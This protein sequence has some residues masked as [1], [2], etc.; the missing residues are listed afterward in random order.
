MTSVIWQALGPHPDQP[1]ARDLARR[2]WASVAGRAT[3]SPRAAVT[4]GGDRRSQGPSGGQSPSAACAESPRPPRSSASDDGCAR[5]TV[6]CPGEARSAADHL[7]ADWGMRIYTSRSTK[8]RRSRTARFAIQ[9][10]AVTVKSQ[11]VGKW[12]ER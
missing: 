3:I 8:P 2:A 1:G 6:S 5:L 9:G 10:G 11:Q 7:Y 12:R 4:R